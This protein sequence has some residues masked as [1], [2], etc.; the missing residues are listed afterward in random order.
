MTIFPFVR[1]VAKSYFNSFLW[2]LIYTLLLSKQCS[3]F[4]MLCFGFTGMDQVISKSYGIK[5]QFYKSIIG[6]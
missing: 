2:Y 5:G 1:E 6:K 4:I 3:P